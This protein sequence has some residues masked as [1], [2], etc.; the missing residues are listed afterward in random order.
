MGQF[1]N[2]WIEAKIAA[3][4]LS[5][6][7]LAERM[8][9]SQPYLSEVLSNKKKPG[10]KF[11][12][13][14][15]RAFGLSVDAVKAIDRTGQLPE[16]LSGEGLLK[17]LLEL[18]KQLPDSERRILLDFAIFLLWRKNTGPKNEINAQNIIGS[19]IEQNISD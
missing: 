7:G 17:E 2:E 13:G 9:I 16:D 14:V 10:A 19:N 4:G 12:L 6:S 11:F 5:I 18:A 15:A 8:G 1:L 3:Q